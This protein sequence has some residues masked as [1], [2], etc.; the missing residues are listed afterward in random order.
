MLRPSK[1]GSGLQLTGFF[2]PFFVWNS[3]GVDLAE[4]N[5]SMRG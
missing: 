4:P 2:G 5:T 3:I 1:D